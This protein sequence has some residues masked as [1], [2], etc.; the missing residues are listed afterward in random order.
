MNTLEAKPYVERF[1]ASIE[2]KRFSTP[3][4]TIE[5]IG[6]Y[7]NITL[8]DESPTSGTPRLGYIA[9]N[10]KG[11]YYIIYCDNCN[12]KCRKCYPTLLNISGAKV[13]KFL[14]GRCAGKKYERKKD[15]EKRALEYLLHPNKLAHLNYNNL[16]LRQSLALLEASFMEDRIRERAERNVSK[17]LDGNS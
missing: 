4:E 5:M 8:G 2:G 3:E 9:S 1:L 12:A 15:Y 7:T 16:S 6:K 14:C 13:M 17:Y 10:I 11:V